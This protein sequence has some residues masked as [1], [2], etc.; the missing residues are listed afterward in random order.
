M[1]ATSAVEPGR[2]TIGVRAVI[3]AAHLD[4]IGAARAGSVIACFSPT[5]A[6]RR[7]STCGSAA[8]VLGCIMWSL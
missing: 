8:V 3:E 6:A 2:S 7:E 1:A 4:Q 5:I